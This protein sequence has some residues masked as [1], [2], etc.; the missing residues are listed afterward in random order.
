VTQ[1][2]VTRIDLY[3]IVRTEP[4]R[5]TEANTSLMV[6]PCLRSDESQPFWLSMRL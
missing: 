3:Q 6:A 2:R 5:S 4:Y 1:T